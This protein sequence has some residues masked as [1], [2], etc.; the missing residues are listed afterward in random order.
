MGRERDTGRRS[1]IRAQRAG[2]IPCVPSQDL[3]RLRKL[4][5]SPRLWVGNHQGSS[6]GR[7]FEKAPLDGNAIKPYRVMPSDREKNDH[8]EENEVEDQKDEEGEK[9]RSIAEEEALGGQEERAE[10]VG[11]QEGEADAPQ[12]RSPEV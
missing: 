4:N 2:M 8:G 7:S 6:D 12:G 9:G 1:D 3:I 5:D 11:R 10:E